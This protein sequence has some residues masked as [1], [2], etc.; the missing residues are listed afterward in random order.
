[1]SRDEVSILVA[2][3]IVSLLI[4]LAFFTE[5]THLSLTAS[6]LITAAVFGIPAFLIW[7]GLRLQGKLQLS[8]C[9]I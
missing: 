9:S 3:R 5:I 8:S 4:W 1:M 2:K 7:F 6:L